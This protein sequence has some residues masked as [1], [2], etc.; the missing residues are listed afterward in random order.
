MT[1]WGWIYASVRKLVKICNPI[2]NITSLQE[3]IKRLIFLYYKNLNV[4]LLFLCLCAL[5]KDEMMIEM[6]GEKIAGITLKKD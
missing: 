1:V 4:F 3:D 6:D 5:W 2:K